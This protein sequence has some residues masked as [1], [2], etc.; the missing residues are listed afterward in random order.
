MKM[1]IPCILL[2]RMVIFFLLL[3]SGF[4]IFQLQNSPNMP[5]NFIT[6]SI[7]HI[8]S[9]F[10]HN[11]MPIVIQTSNIWS[12]FFNESNIPEEDLLLARV[13]NNSMSHIV[14]GPPIESFDYMLECKGKPGSAVLVL[15]DKD[16]KQQIDT[17]YFM[18]LRLRI[19]M[20][21]HATKFVIVSNLI[22]C[23]REEQMEYSGEFLNFLWNYFRMS[24][25]I[26]LIS[27]P[28][29]MRENEDS[30]D[31]ITWYPNDQ[32][33]TCLESLDHFIILDTWLS[34]EK[35]F[36]N[37]RELFTPKVIQTME[38]C[39][40]KVLLFIWPP[41]IFLKKTDKGK[42]LIDG[43]Y[44]RVLNMI[45][46]IMLIRY[47]FNSYPDKHIG[48]IILPVTEHKFHSDN[49]DYV[50]PYF[51]DDLTFFIPAGNMIPRWQSLFRCFSSNMWCFV[52]VSYFMGT[53][54]FLFFEVFDNLKGNRIFYANTV[55]VFFNTFCSS[56]GIAMKENFHSMNSY[57]FLTL[58][59]FYCMQIYTA[60]QASLTG[61]IVNPGE[62]SPIKT[63]DQLKE[64]GFGLWQ[65][66]RLLDIIETDVDINVS[67]SCDS[68]DCFKILLENPNSAVL[69]FKTY[70]EMFVQGYL[71][72]NGRRPLVALEESF[73]KVYISLITRIGCMI[74]K[75]FK[76]IIQRLVIGG[77]IQKW[78][79]TMVEHH[80]N[81]YYNNV[82][83][84]TVFSFSL[85]HLQGAF[86][87]LI[88]GLVISTI[89]FV[90]EFLI[91]LKAC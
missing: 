24:D 11:N 27:K 79:N 88:F 86:Y 46:E 80:W 72:S 68:T 70:S 89:A 45:S 76:L 43:I 17:L 62:F 78:A 77:F 63:I 18:M 28:K 53:L 71:T 30:F 20:R 19:D 39:T 90:C 61:F 10:L 14:L 56:L 4:G 57:L 6:D 37:G 84:D 64:S 32:A 75:R 74:N 81:M 51:T 31:A 15:T 5:E 85:N 54:A 41:F 59:L 44:I 16:M 55:T 40:F 29:A 49:C 7:L 65:S 66:F 42:T 91:Q 3:P 67:L 50:Y 35:R 26:V 73:L 47:S 13:N 22:P 12:N 9:R 52:I 36:I 33:D 1:D 48:D 8:M 83:S 34:R 2:Y 58:W 21:N 69:T 60:Y 25:V 38:G 87:L 82:D 23:S